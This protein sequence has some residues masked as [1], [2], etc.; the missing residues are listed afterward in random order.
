MSEWIE[1]TLKFVLPNLLSALKPIFITFMSVGTIGGISEGYVL[2]KK[3]NHDLKTAKLVNDRPFVEFIETKE[4]KIK[5]RT[6]LVL[7]EVPPECLTISEEEKKEIVGKLF[8]EAIEEFVTT[9]EKDSKDINLFFMYDNMRSLKVEQ[10]KDFVEKYL[11]G[12]A[13]YYL[14]L[15]NKITISRNSKKHLFHELFH[16][17]TT[18]RKKDTIY[19]G[20]NQFNSDFEIGT[21]I[22]EGYTNLLVEH[23]FGL[24][25]N[26][27]K[28]EVDLARR[29]EDIVGRE[30]MKQYYFKA[31]LQGLIDELSKYSSLDNALKLIQT[32]DYINYITIKHRFGVLPIK[33]AYLNK[34]LDMS[35]NLLEEMINN[36]NENGIQQKIN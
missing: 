5:G 24:K 33:K 20:F 19:C 3:Y 30:N 10:K 29:V 35:Y 17:A 4:S 12:M 23:Y 27:Y 32:I 25:N 21:G 15:K 31:D 18:F 6:D 11:F 2:N 26:S 16:V 1:E 34:S 28:N 14:I 13:G 22:N 7:T 36:K 9:V 8:S